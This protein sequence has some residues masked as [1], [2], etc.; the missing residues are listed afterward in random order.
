M[1]RAKSAMRMTERAGR[2]RAFTTERRAG[3]CERRARHR[4]YLDAKDQ[5]DPLTVAAFSRLVT[6]SDHLFMWMTQ[7]ERPG[8]V[9]MCFTTCET[10]Y[11]DAPELIE[12]V[13]W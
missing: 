11:Q 9:R 8:A 6:E 5:G 12:S 1:K 10:P 7:L 3:R 13:V 4:A 2:E